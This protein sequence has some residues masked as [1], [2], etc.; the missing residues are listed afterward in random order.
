MLVLSRKI[1]ESIIINGDIEIK[2]VALE[3]GR[4]R[5]GI[6]APKHY[7]IHRKEVFEKIQAE[8]RQA[9]DS[10]KSADRLK[11]IQLKTIERPE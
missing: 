2:I 10:A 4:V 7:E 6:D 9:A 1:E 5:I 3:D 11:S 8:N